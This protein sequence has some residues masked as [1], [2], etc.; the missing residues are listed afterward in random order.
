MARWTAATL[1][2]LCGAGLAPRPVQAQAPAAGPGAP[3]ADPHL[4][5]KLP[6]G[7]LALALI[8]VTRGNGFDDRTA[9]T[10][11]EVLLA[12]LDRTAHFRVIGRTD[13]NAL[14]TLENQK[15]AVG[16]SDSSCMAQIAGAL[17]VDLV[18]TADVG[19]LG[20]TTVIS[21][22]VLNVGS[23][24]VVVR[25]QEMVESD[26]ALPAAARSIAAQVV[27]ALWPDAG[28]G[29]APA[30]SLPAAAV[31]APLVKG[32]AMSAGRAVGIGAAV[33]G[34]V[35]L[36]VGTGLG[37]MASQQDAHVRT[38]KQPGSAV[39]E[40]VNSANGQAL[41]AD[42]LFGVGGALGAA[43]VGLVVAF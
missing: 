22:K 30:A 34:V 28:A 24:T 39:A 41:G 6:P 1:A 19:R 40:Q 3:A 25:A 2:L 43:G 36:A 13:I 10:I 42:V 35:A 37:V 21:L 8:S 7:R 23:A 16:C 29:S 31:A 12:A 20:T 27:Q 11:E 18:A 26:S 38:T 5:R 4:A 33:L 15:E 17:G 14:L 32:H 9:N